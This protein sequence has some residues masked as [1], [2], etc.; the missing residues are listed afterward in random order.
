MQIA[1]KMIYSLLIGT[2]GRSRNWGGGGGGGPTTY[3]G[4]FVSEINKI[5]SKKKGGGG[6]GGGG[7]GLDPP[8]SGPEYNPAS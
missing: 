7:G 8:G 5:F 2:R 1:P 6:G 3:S 4:Q